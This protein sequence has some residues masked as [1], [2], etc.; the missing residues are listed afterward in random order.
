MSI[1]QDVQSYR[2]I[3][4][5]NRDALRRSMVFDAR[6]VGSIYCEVRSR[7]YMRSYIL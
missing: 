5:R 6:F 3:R 1:V 7:L 2:M 4:I